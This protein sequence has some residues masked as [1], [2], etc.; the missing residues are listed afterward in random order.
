MRLRRKMARETAAVGQKSEYIYLKKKKKDYEKWKK[1]I[2]LFDSRNKKRK[3]RKK[4]ILLDQ[5]NKLC[6]KFAMVLCVI[7]SLLFLWGGK[8]ESVSRLFYRWIAVYVYISRK[9]KYR[10]VWKWVIE[11]KYFLGEKNEWNAG[12]KGWLLLLWLQGWNNHFIH[13]QLKCCKYCS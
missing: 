13:H 2:K 6:L 8:R 10:G 5:K 3:R 7:L 11:V 4:K 12:P 9:A 1:E